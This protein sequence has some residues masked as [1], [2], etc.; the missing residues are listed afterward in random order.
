MPAMRKY[1]L[2]A[3]V[4]M[5]CGVAL[6]QSDNR[7]L[8]ERAVDRLNCEAVGWSM[9]G[10]KDSK[11][12]EQCPCGS[13]VSYG[14]L[15]KCIGDAGKTQALSTD[16]ESVKKDFK[17]G[18]TKDEAVQYLTSAVFNDSTKHGPLCAFVSRTAREDKKDKPRREHARF[19][20]ITTTVAGTLD[21][22]AV[23]PPPAPAQVRAQAPV[24][25]S[26]PA[27]ESGPGLLTLFL[28]WLA[29]VLA[30]VSVTLWL[31]SR[32]AGRASEGGLSQ[33]IRDY[34][35]RKINERPQPDPWQVPSSSHGQRNSGRGQDQLGDRVKKLE[36]EVDALRDQLAR[37]NR[38]AS[39]SIPEP[40]A[41][42]SETL[43]L[44]GPDENGSFDER[45]ASP[46]YKEGA[47]VYRLT[48]QG[49]GW[50]SFA[51]HDHPS[52]IKMALAYPDRI[53]KPVCDATGAMQNAKRI[54]TE[55]P[56]EVRLE[57]GRWRMTSKARIRYEH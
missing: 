50:A 47:S 40:P 33:E 18:W 31:M 19:T 30:S 22:W 48:K 17:D 49:P 3:M 4:T 57:N 43:F 28:V 41:S 27:K 6:A 21:G 44:P 56:G 20:D 11:F 52:A 5:P 36:K 16:I 42:V 46:A 39:P 12:S 51:I 54:V 23:A 24:P 9:E 32:W 7:A 38:L 8:F 13:D 14:Q 2:A 1:V 37:A 35:K 53:I 25:T 10:V 34:V 26:S 45:A 55:T 29:S 15:T